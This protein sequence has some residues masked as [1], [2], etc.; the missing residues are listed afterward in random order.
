MK[1]SLLIK[2]WKTQ[3]KNYRFIFAFII[4]VL[5]FIPYVAAQGYDVVDTLFAGD[6]TQG[7]DVNPVTN[8]IYVSALGDNAVNHLTNRIY[9]TYSGEDTLSVIAPN[10]GQL[11]I[12]AEDYE[13]G[14][15]NVAYYD[16]TIGNAGGQYRNDDVDI[17]Y[18]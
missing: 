18:H 4:G 17:W 7:V 2:W 10:S 15:Q 16:K 11:T 14:G 8:R 13:L 1:T 9:V 5:A 12:Q 6:V 3:A